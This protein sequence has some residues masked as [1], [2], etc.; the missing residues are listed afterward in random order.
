VV[1]GAVTAF[2][3]INDRE[4][5]VKFAIDSKLMEYDKIN[6]HPLTNEATTTI[7]RDD[8]LAFAKRVGHEAMIVDLA[9]EI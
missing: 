1:P 4:G 2:G 6:C 9:E 3:V 8:L 7:G 5:A